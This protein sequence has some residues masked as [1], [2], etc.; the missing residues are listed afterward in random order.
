M[1]SVKIWRKYLVANTK[2]NQQTYSNPFSWSIHL[3]LFKEC[4]GNKMN[5]EQSN[6]CWRLENIP[7]SR[8]A[9]GRQE[10]RPGVICGLQCQVQESFG[11]VP[12]PSRCLQHLQEQ[13]STRAGSS[14]AWAAPAGLS[15]G[16]PAPAQVISRA[17]AAPCT[18]HKGDNF[19]PGWALLGV[20]R[21]CTPISFPKA[22]LSYG[23]P[24][25]ELI[26]E[27]RIR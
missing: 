4:V 2:I 6:A 1:S 27:L 21:S 18:A 16:T 25:L 13:Q 14:P 7:F 23:F 11:R 8:D 15:W 17:P 19:S 3:A 24:L 20:E 12:S 10:Q 5:F 22:P 26:L 9:P